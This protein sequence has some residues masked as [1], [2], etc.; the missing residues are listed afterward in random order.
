MPVST[1]A[2]S[3]KRGSRILDLSGG[4]RS[5]PAVR[6]DARSDISGA[7]VPAIGVTT[8]KMHREARYQARHGDQWRYDEALD[9]EVDADDAHEVIG[10]AYTDLHEKREAKLAGTGASKVTPSYQSK[11]KSVRMF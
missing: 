11:P 1:N 7:A 10:Q 5:T 9:V 4:P 3:G 8:A 6:V 2:Q